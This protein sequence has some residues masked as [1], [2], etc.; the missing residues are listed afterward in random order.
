VGIVAGAA[1]AG[2]IDKM[3]DSEVSWA[4]RQRRVSG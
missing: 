1:A 4:D 3:I 2:P